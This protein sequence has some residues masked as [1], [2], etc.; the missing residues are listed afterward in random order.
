M[1]TGGLGKLAFLMCHHVVTQLPPPGEMTNR[2]HLYEEC[3]DTQKQ[4]SLT[5]SHN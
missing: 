4:R 5:V 3:H 1:P 2:P